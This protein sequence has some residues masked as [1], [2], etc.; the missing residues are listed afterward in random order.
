MVGRAVVFDVMGTLFD[1]APVRRRLTRLGA[2]EGALEAWFG[3]MLH[4]SA[5]LTLVDEF[6]R[7]REIGRTTLLTT[8]AQLEVESEHV[9]EV[10]Q[11]LGELDPYPD[12]AQAFDLLEDVGATRRPHRPH[13]RVTL[14]ARPNDCREHNCCDD[15]IAGDRS[16]HSR[17]FSD[18]GPM[19]SI[20]GTSEVDDERNL[21]RS[22]P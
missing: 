10:L 4:T 17:E 8:L 2:P 15:E 1:L 13:V 3:R 11:A 7:F 5:A 22:M 14:R 9:D 12:A 18:E 20:D 6:H 21:G 16:R 19:G